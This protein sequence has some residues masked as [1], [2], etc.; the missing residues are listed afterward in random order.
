VGRA[1]RPAGEVAEYLASV[2]ASSLAREDLVAA[3]ARRNGPDA[4]D[5]DGLALEPD[6][7][8]LIP[9]ELAVENRLLPV[10]RGA[11]LLFVAVP[12]GA[13]RDGMEELEHLSGL[14]LEAV[15]VSEIDVLGVLVKAHQLL[16]R[17]GA[18]A[19]PAP[20]PAAGGADRPGP[21][22][23]ALGLP[24]VILRRLR[25]LLSAPLGLILVA[26]PA[27]SGKSTTLAAAAGEARSRGFRTAS[28]DPSHGVA[29]LEETLRE[30]P[31]VLTVDETASPA[32]A[33]R[34]LRAAVEGRR[35]LM[36]FRAPDAAS[37]RARLEGLNVDPHLI[38]T[39]ARAGLSQRLLRGVCPDC[40]ETRPEDPATLEDL[41][42][43]SLLRGVPLRRG[44]GCSA[45]GR[46]GT[47]GRVALFEYGEAGPEGG[48]RAGFQ[49]LIADGLGKLVAGRISLKELTEQVPFTQVLQAADRLSVRRVGP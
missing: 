41:R 11:G 28:F 24:D 21:D 45:C 1:N 7:L 10:H 36:A 19:A 4:F 44:R 18:A 35:V 14:R 17:R 25:A 13:P 48:L 43:E 38:A 16:R 2:G 40:A 23:D 47:R 42:L 3:L 22:L 6:L 9:E 46:G 5:V 15:E 12:E 27:G 26:G 31:D 49:P 20:R 33:S 34:A 32:L 8:R 39:A 37:A 29:V 30:D